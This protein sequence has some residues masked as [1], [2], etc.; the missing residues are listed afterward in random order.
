MRVLA[1]PLRVVA[2]AAL[3]A[4]GARDAV[5]ASRAKAVPG[6]AGDYSILMRDDFAVGRDLADLPG[7]LSI[8]SLLHGIAP[9]AVYELPE[10]GGFTE[11]DP[12]KLSLYGNSWL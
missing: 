12:K 7:S 8:G 10:S 2:M 11:V 9:P 1:R 4:L 3:V 5:G 6:E